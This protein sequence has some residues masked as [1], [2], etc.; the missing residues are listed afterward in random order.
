MWKHLC[1]P[2]HRW[3]PG[4]SHSRVHT[5]CD[6]IDWEL[7]QFLNRGFINPTSTNAK[8]SM[9][10]YNAKDCNVCCILTS[11]LLSENEFWIPNGWPVIYFGN[12][13]CIDIRGHLLSPQF[14]NV[15]AER[16]SLLTLDKHNDS[17]FFFLIKNRF[18][19][20]PSP[21]SK[22]QAHKRHQPNRTRQ[23]TIRQCKNKFILA[24]E[25]CCCNVNV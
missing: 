9:C 4:W 21:F 12:R 1:I 18:F 5:V 15:F 17:F 7:S 11:L 13:F 24:T 20:P 14:T 22:D 2:I 16:T 23:N 25:N 8:L 19:L 10:S 6:E 3:M